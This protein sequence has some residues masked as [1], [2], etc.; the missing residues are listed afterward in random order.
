MQKYVTYLSLCDKAKGP[1]DLTA[2]ALFD[3]LIRQWANNRH[4][5]VTFTMEFFQGASTTTVHRHLKALRMAGYVRLAID[6]SN[7]RCK[8][9][10]PTP[11]A[12]AYIAS[13]EA[14]MQ[15]AVH[16]PA[17]RHQTPFTPASKP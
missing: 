1:R 10:V 6:A 13:I 11:K 14:A 8:K 2:R 15:E 3:W 12:L 7:Q 5:Q 17:Y 16:G 9:I 4:P